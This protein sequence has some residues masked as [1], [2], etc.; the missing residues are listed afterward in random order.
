MNIIELRADDME[1]CSPTDL[2]AFQERFLDA[3]EQVHTQLW[4][5]AEALSKNRHDAE[6]LVSETILIAYKQF[7]QVQNQD[8]FCY[9]LFTIARRLHKKRR[10]RYRLFGEVTTEQYEDSLQ[11]YETPPDTRAD[12][13]ALYAAIDELPDKMKEAVVLF[14]LSGLSLEEIRRIQGGTLSGVKSRITRGREKLALLLGTT[15]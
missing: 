10:W 14:E 3:V 11:G 15:E 4:R 5:Y 2:T 6:D 12:F 1:N 8:S 13:P 7:A 9:Y